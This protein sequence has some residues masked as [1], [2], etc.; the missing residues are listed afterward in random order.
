[1]ESEFLKVRIQSGLLTILHFTGNEE[2][3]QKEFLSTKKSNQT[4]VP[5]IAGKGNQKIIIKNGKQYVVRKV[6]HSKGKIRKPETIDINAI[7][8]SL[9]VQNVTKKITLSTKKSLKKTMN[10]SSRDLYRVL[11][12]FFFLNFKLSPTK[13]QNW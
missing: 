11:L 8:K 4:T 5:K 13:L 1:M 3:V 6:K 7:L 2:P 10:T 9:S 12:D